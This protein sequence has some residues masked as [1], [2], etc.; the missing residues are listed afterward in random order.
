MREYIG[1]IFIAVVWIIAALSVGFGKEKDT[2]DMK[3]KK[4]E[5]TVV[6]TLQITQHLSADSAFIKTYNTENTRPWPKYVQDWAHRIEAALANIIIADDITCTEI[7]VF[8][9]E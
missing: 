3:P 6:Y 2:E 1:Y 5:A 4:N 9:N 7:Q 8:K